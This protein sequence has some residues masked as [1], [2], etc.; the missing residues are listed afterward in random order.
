MSLLWEGGWG[1]FCFHFLGVSLGFA[2]SVI[3]CSTMGFPWRGSD[4]SS[5]IWRQEGG[6]DIYPDII[7]SDRRRVTYSS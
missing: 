1:V 6:R 7:V 5:W 4:A 2:L 3:I